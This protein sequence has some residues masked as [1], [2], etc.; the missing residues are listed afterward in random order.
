MDYSFAYDDDR[1]LLTVTQSGYWT[2]ETFQAF[3]REFLRRHEEIRARHGNYRVFAECA[4]FKVQSTEIGMAFGAMFTRLMNENH[5]HYAI[6]AGSA[7]NR[8]QAKRVI[9]QSNVEVFTDRDEAMAW[10]FLPGS[11]AEDGF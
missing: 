4:D 3:E 9:P 6:I 10:L 1:I 5:G 2:L 11:L 7:L 8:I